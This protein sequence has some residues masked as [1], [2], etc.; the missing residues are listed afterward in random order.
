[1]RKETSVAH[2]QKLKSYFAIIIK[3]NENE[4][5]KTMV[6]S[7]THWA[8]LDE[9]IKKHMT[10]QD[11]EFYGETEPIDRLTAFEETIYDLQR[12]EF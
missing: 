1:M 9:L 2:V 11:I 5:K 4:E 10:D 12:E 3:N 6:S 7:N 8:D